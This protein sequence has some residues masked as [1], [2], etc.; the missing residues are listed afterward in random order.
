MCGRNDALNLNNRLDIMEKLG[1]E[2]EAF[3]KDILPAIGC[4]DLAFCCEI[5]TGDFHN[6]ELT[7]KWAWE[8][9]G[10]E[11]QKVFRLSV[12]DTAD[13]FIDRVKAYLFDWIVT[14]VS[15]R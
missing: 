7:I 8:R 11:G 10:K 14:A 9:L 2:F 4:D 5:G 6:C 13:N 15:L 3:K 12:L 1:L